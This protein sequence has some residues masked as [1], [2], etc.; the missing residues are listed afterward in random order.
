M[1]ESSLQLSFLHSAGDS[2]LLL[3]TLR[4]QDLMILLSFMG[5]LKLIKELL[6]GWNASISQESFYTVGFV[7]LL[8]LILRYVCI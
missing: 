1:S 6:T 5:F 8:I 4:R 2:L 3:F 7:V